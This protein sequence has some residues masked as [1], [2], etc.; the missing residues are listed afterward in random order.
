VNVLPSKP[1]VRRS[2][3]E[4]LLV[5]PQFRREGGEALAFGQAVHTFIATYWRHLQAVGRDSDLTAVST[6]A[7]AAWAMTLGLKQSRFD[8][9]AALCQ[10]FADAH[11]GDLAD[12]VAIEETLV[13][14]AGFALLNCTPDRID[15]LAPADPDEDPTWLL[16]RDYKTEQGEMEHEFQIRWYAQQALLHWPSVGRIDFEIDLIRSRSGP[17]ERVTFERGELDAWWATTLDALRRRLAAPNAPAVGGPACEGCA[18]RYRCAEA[19]VPVFLEPT[20]DAGADVLLAEWHRLDEAAKAR[21]QALELYYGDK[22]WRVVN[23]EEIGYLETRDPSFE[24]LVGAAQMALFGHLSGMDPW[25][26]VR[27]A[28]PTNRGLRDRLVELGLAQYRTKPG[29]FKTRKAEPE[30]RR[31]RREEA[32]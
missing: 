24:L 31:K 7:A 5:C 28:A 6:L 16:I 25:A 22:P 29:E 20:D 1:E 12:V 10:R 8:E 18:L 13:H 2:L 23:G 11:L 26:Y 27:A 30:R 3:A 4:G 32:S 19:I 15:R 9:F 21:W 14:D 17:F